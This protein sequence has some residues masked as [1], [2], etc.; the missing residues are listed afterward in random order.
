MPAPLT[1]RYAA[2]EKPGVDSVILAED[3]AGMRSQALGLAEAAGLQPRMVALQPRL[4]WWW[5]PGRYWP[6]PLRAVRLPTPPEPLAIGCGG[7]AAPVLA[8]L[9][10]RGRLAVQIQHPRMDIRLFDQVVVTRHDGLTGPNVIVTRTALH[11]ATAARLAAARAEWTGRLA[12][13]PRPL[14]AVLVGGSNGRFRLE[15]P[16]GAAL[17]RDLATM[18]KADC[19]GLAV[20]PSRRTAPSVQAALREALLPLGAMVWDGNGENPYFGLLACADAIV[21]TA[22]SVSMVS[23]A[24]ATAVPVLLAELPGRSR[25]IGAFLHGLRQDGRVRPFR[26]RLEM[27]ETSPL[28]DTQAAADTLRQ[29]LGF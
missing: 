23:E 19:V 20:T 29:R 26:G 24:V 6:S 9:R 11:G 18:M 16:E 17:A 25:R 15:A 28:D 14:V 3:F 1:R 5:M 2:A 10:R 7:K 4:P 12:H 21:V 8:A 13:L 27:W 22:D